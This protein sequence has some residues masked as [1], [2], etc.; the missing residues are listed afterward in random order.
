MKPTSSDIGDLQL[1]DPKDPDNVML[2]RRLDVKQLRALGVPFDGAC[3]ELAPGAETPVD[4]HAESEIWVC[5]HGSGQLTIGNVARQF[6]SGDIVFFESW[7]SHQ[8]LNTGP[9]PIVVFSVWWPI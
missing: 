3:F 6:A 8:L 5:L 4:G 7:Q 9:D 2:M 1:L